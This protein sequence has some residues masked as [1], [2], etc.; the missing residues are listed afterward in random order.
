MHNRIPK[1]KKQGVVHPIRRS[2]LNLKFIL[3]IFVL[4]K[5]KNNSLLSYGFY[6]LFV[7]VLTKGISL[8]QC[9]AIHKEVYKGGSDAKR[10]SIGF[11]L[12]KSRRTALYIMVRS[13]RH[14]RWILNVT[15]GVILESITGRH[16]LLILPV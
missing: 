14:S 6:S 2:G 3:E 4:I 7:K 13:K 16:I 15:T 11:Q 10:Y 12:V 9:T 1:F 8:P 5:L